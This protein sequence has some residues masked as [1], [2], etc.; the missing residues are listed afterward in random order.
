MTVATEFNVLNCPL[1]RRSIIEASAGTGKTWNICNLYLRLLLE[2]KLEVSQI[3]VVTFTHAATDELRQRIR[4]CISDALDCL[5]NHTSGTGNAFVVELLHRCM[6]NGHSDKEIAALLRLAFQSFDQAA[7]FTIHSFCQRALA[8]S[9]FSSGQAFSVKAETDDSELVRETVNDFWRTH[10]AGNDLPPALSRWIQASG[11]SP[12]P[13]K[14]RFQRKK[15]SKKNK[16]PVTLELLLRQRMKKPL[17][18]LRWP[19]NLPPYSQSPDIAL[20]AIKTAFSQLEAIYTETSHCWQ[21]EKEAILTLLENSYHDGA[22]NKQS[23]KLPHIADA[24]QEYE[25]LFAA[26]DCLFMLDHDDKTNRMMATWLQSKTNKNQQTPQHPFFDLADRLDACCRELQKLLELSCYELM[27]RF[28]EE[29]PENLNAKKRQRRTIAFN[30]MLSNLYDALHDPEMR[31]LADAISKR[32]PAALIDEF[33]DTDPLQYAIF[34]TIYHQQDAPVF[35]VGDPKQAIY[36]FRNADLFTYLTAREQTDSRYTLLNNYRSVPGLINACNILF[37]QNQRVFM[38]DG[39]DFAPASYAAHNIPVLCD[40]DTNPAA[41]RVWMLSLDSDKPMLR[42]DGISHSLEAVANEIARLIT[43]GANG[44]C[45]I[46]D[47]PVQA[48]DI[49][50]LVRSHKEAAQVRKALARHGVGSVSL[51]KDNVFH[52]REANELECVL[53]AMLEPGNEQLLMAMLATEMMGMDS[54]NIEAI[55]DDEAQLSAIIERFAE[56][57]KA[58]LTYGAGYALRWFMNRENI[59]FRLLAF[60]DGERRMT[61]LMHL[62]EFIHRESETYPTPEALMEWYVLHRENRITADE[63]ELRLETDRNLVQVMT[64]HHAKGLQFGFVFCPFLWIESKNNKNEDVG[65]EYYDYEKACRVIDLRM[66]SDDEKKPLTESN[67]LLVAAESMR[68]IYVALTRA[69]YRCYLVA[70]CYAT[71]NNSKNPSTAQSRRSLLNWLVAGNGFAPEDWIRPSDDKKKDSK[72]AKNSN[73]PLPDAQILASW[74]A[75]K[76]HTDISI[77]P[78][79]NMAFIS[80]NAVNRKIPTLSARTFDR[81]LAADWRMSSFSGLMR[82]ATV[83]TNAGDHDEYVADDSSLQTRR[84]E[85]AVVTAPDDILMFPK[86][87]YAGSCLHAVF[88]NADFTDKTTWNTAVKTALSLFPQK[89]EPPLPLAETVLEAMAANMLE[90]VLKTPLP[91]N[92]RLDMLDNAHKLVEWSFCLSSARLSDEQ[93][94]RLTKTVSRNMP[95]LAFNDMTAYLNGIIDL[96]FEANGKFWLLDWKSNHLGYRPQDYDAKNLST[97]MDEHGYHWQ[98]LLYTVALHRYLSSRIRDYHYDRHFGGIYYL[99][100]RGVR[101]DWKNTDGSPSGVFF[102][103]PDRELIMS[104]DRLLMPVRPSDKGIPE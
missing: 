86:G 17:A 69:I 65:L 102:T 48:G 12:T 15:T 101:P 98:Y 85:D 22:L 49:A 1:N 21:A 74:M 55:A 42:R 57:R 93:M 43:G 11:F 30:D 78:L 3:L 45:M 4:N 19:D 72:Q 10:V 35:M 80:A 23:V 89:S 60:P 46:G 54:T 26:N 68:L 90:N 20:Q 51:S 29:A 91:C 97:A 24:F 96:V 99:F 104:L 66:L 8:L 32:F 81:Y 5:E 59:A 18:D 64:I 61:N 84:T 56:Y 2:K 87:T 44:T 25:R 34:S 75:L 36:S 27:R 82:N 9:A 41:F 103:R 77:A 39:L 33:Q 83:E 79:P 31:W 47:R 37:Q 94:N 38:Q 76:N 95:Q 73:L 13:P 63:E 70:G 40:D 14:S 28:L 7:I 58:W 50:V 100:V 52:S 16:F 67:R 71:N 92:I 88:E 6:A 53:S 62:F